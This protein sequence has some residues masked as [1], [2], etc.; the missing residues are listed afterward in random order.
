MPDSLVA[1]MVRVAVGV[2]LVIALLC[3][4]A[5]A[6][7]QAYPQRPVRIIVN[8]T[9]GGGVDALARIAAQHPSVG[10]AVRGRQ[11]YRRRR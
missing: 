5:L 8:V 11:P 7:A 4:T 9:A 2:A 3:A 1:N 6:N 10:P